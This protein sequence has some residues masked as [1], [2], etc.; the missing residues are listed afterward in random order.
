M[1]AWFE[2]LEAFAIDVILDRRYGRRAG[3][4]RW[5]LG[6]LAVVYL[7]IVQARRALYDCRFYRSHSHGCLVISVGNLTVGGTGKTPVVEMLARALEQGGRRVAILSRG[8]KSVPRPLIVRI[9]E[10]FTKRKALFVPRVVSD[11]TSLLL[12]SRTAGD[13]PFMLANN[14]RNV[15]VLVDRD[16]VK[17]GIY[18]IREFR[19]DALILDDGFQ[20]LRMRHGVEIVL[21]DRQAPFGNEHILPRGTLREHPNQLRRATHI[22]LT[23]CDGSDNSDVIARIRRYNRTAE[24]IECAHRPKHLKNFITGEVKSLDFL[25]GLRVGA[26]CGIAVPESFEAALHRLTAKVEISKFYAD[27]HR[28]SAKEIERFIRRCARRELDAVITTEKD[29]VRIPRIVEPDLPIYY[30]RVEI[31]ILAGHETW[32]RLIGRLTHRQTALS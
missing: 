18:A 1:R 2:A 24:I 16:R 29:A 8:Y 26:I 21:I 31:E 4:L 25:S 32:E 22:F 30:L 6:I 10:R 12:D 3:I 5:I 27:H 17:S 11:G 15:A 19:A 13:E 9:V 14:L 20:Y 23:K 28:Y 7:L